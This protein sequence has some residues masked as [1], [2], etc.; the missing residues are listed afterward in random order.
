MTSFVTAAASPMRILYVSSVFISFL[1]SGS[2]VGFQRFLVTP[3]SVEVMEGADVFLRCIVENQQGKAQWTKDGFALG[4]ERQVPGYP[5][6]SYSG[7]PALGQHHLVISGIT[8]TEDGEYQCQVGPTQT[9]PPIW[10]AANVTVLVAPR[11]VEFSGWRDGSV[12]EVV[13]G[14]SITLECLVKDARPAPTVWWYRDGLQ[15]DQ[16]LVEER[17]EASSLVRRWSVRSRIALTASPEDDGKLFTCEAD[18]PALRG[19]S[20]PLLA[21]ITLSVLHQPG[22]PTISGYKTGEVLVAGERRTLVCRVSGG[23]P[24][25]WVTWHRQGLLLD[26]TT[27]SD[28]AGV[29]NTHQLTATA[30]DDGAIYECR[31]NSDLLQ[32]PMVANV[33]LT[34]YYV[35]SFV[36][37]IGP[38]QVE[39]GAS[40]SLTC[41]TSK[42]NPP[43]SIIWRVQGETVTGEPETMVRVSTGGWVTTSQL[44]HH[45]V[46]S[47]KVT[48]VVVECRAL[49][50][51][52][53]QIVSKTR[54]VAI[55]KPA[56]PPRFEGDLERNFLAGTT[57]DLVCSSIGGHPPPTIRIY[58]EEEE[59][60]TE[61][62]R[63][64]NVTRGRGSVGLTP[65]DNGA[66]VTCEV[67]NAGS[68]SAP[69]TVY[70]RLVVR[71]A[72][73]EV[74]GSVTPTTVEEGA[75]VRLS[76]E[77]SSSLPPSNITWRSE[78]VTLDGATITNTQGAFGGTSTRSEVQV[79]TTAGDNGRKFVC[80]ASNGLGPPVHTT[81]TTHVLHPPVWLSRPPPE[82]DVYEGADLIVSASAAANPGPLRYWWRRGEE[83]LM[84]TGQEL[85]LGRISR[86]N[87]GHYSVSAYS[88]RG[89]V[90]A[91]FYLNVQYGPEKVES[92]D[93]VS[94]EENG[95]VS[96]QCSA[97]G[98]PVPHLTWTR[99]P[100]NTHNSSGAPLASGVGVARLVMES[101]RRADTG[102]YLCHARN[103]VGS[104]P[105]TRTYVVVAQKV[106]AAA[107]VQGL[108]GSWAAVGGIGR[109]VC[110]VRAAPPP[111]FV[112]SSQ[113]GLILLNSDKYTIHEPQLVDGLVLWSSVLEVK[114][115]NTQ[116][117]TL[118]RCHAH[119]AHGSDSVVVALNPPSRPHPPVNF[120]INK[121]VGGE[122]WV[123]WAPNLEGGAPSGYTLR[124]R[125]AGSSVYQYVEVSGGGTTTARVTGLA[126]ATEYTAAIQA[127]NDHG[128]SHFV[129]LSFFTLLGKTDG[130]TSLQGLAGATSKLP[131]G[132]LAAKPAEGADNLSD[133]DRDEDG[134][135]RVPRLI[136]LIMT[137][138]GAALLALNISIIACFVRRRAMNRHPSGASSSKTASLGTFGVTPASTPGV[139]PSEVFLSLNTMSSNDPSLSPSEYQNG[140]RPHH[141]GDEAVQRPVEADSPS[142]NRTA[143]PAEAEASHFD[144]DLVNFPTE[145]D[146]CSL[147][148]SV[149]D[150]VPPDGPRRR[151][152][153]SDTY[154]ADDQFSLCSDRSTNS[155]HVY[156]QGF[157]RPLSSLGG[158]QQPQQATPQLIQD[159]LHALPRHS[160]QQHLLRLAQA[161]QLFLHT[162]QQHLHNLQISQYHN[163]AQPRH[164]SPRETRQ[165]KPQSSEEQKYSPQRTQHQNNKPL[166][167]HNQQGTQNSQ[168]PEE[169]QHPRSQH[170]LPAS[171]ERELQLT[172]HLQQPRRRSLQNPTHMRSQSCHIKQ[173]T[174]PN[175]QPQQ[176]HPGEQSPKQRSSP[177]SQTRSQQHLKQTRSHQTHTRKPQPHTQSPL[178]Q[179]PRSHSSKEQ[180]PQ[181][182]LQQANFQKLPSEALT[183]PPAYSN[184]NP[185]DL[186]SFK[187]DNYHV[188][189]RQ[190]LSKGGGPA[191]YST[192]GT[193]RRR[194]TPTHF[195]TLQRPRSSRTQTKQ[196]TNS[197]SH[198]P[199]EP[200]PPDTFQMTPFR[201]EIEETFCPSSGVPSQQEN[202]GSSGYSSSP[203]H[204]TGPSA[205]EPDQRATI[206]QN[207]KDTVEAN[208]PMDN[209]R[210]F[211]DITSTN[212]SKG[213][214][215]AS[216]I[217]ASLEHEADT[218]DTSRK[219][220][221]HNN[222]APQNDR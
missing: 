130:P 170:Q 74:S 9:N 4:F 122:V 36:S 19:G 195:A 71:F 165:H 120:T 84:G 213:H 39:E 215:A 145:P 184:L 214:I 191:G 46:R 99:E 189:Y 85:Q 161:Q 136:L 47:R 187:P 210:V 121:M 69:L 59:V 92:S 168:S 112:W 15:L 53:E 86:H 219:P 10:A 173:Q 25:P 95:R 163:N 82:V 186:F 111:T 80:E 62:T 6:Y 156:S 133:E 131:T 134:G 162:P 127:T 167:Q 5:R 153:S 87:T 42:S 140:E 51:A 93:R 35:P 175:A 166:Q 129:S 188:D 68:T 13:A 146:V 157:L 150:N 17:V 148:S 138:T 98:N 48:E 38:T 200:C 91:S 174:D 105:P 177:E 159:T 180:S 7:D 197:K 201:F 12:V 135:S 142:S 52:I 107:D 202:S 29:I 75:I 61:V 216:R 44:T 79:R 192:L 55:T 64:L 76:C 132:T 2:A 151:R 141:A 178:Q 54:I 104:A 24:R 185:I 181:T 1:R 66:R 183:E 45:K 110:H 78:D 196:N 207:Q 83:T 81:L 97:S 101:A 115:I 77:S 56:G 124:Y 8:I 3:E 209:P 204:D 43:V 118:Y 109:L 28:A 126:P 33:S 70:A 58:K 169:H 50:P 128:R 20:D 217:Q 11:S 171:H 193:R 205:Q 116:D 160:Q 88:Q 211:E 137:L 220:R 49:N 139:H 67:A 72:P 206:P 34:V 60:P 73:W 102:V 23:N 65:A 31:V 147:G 164:H 203:P 154:P 194:Q 218:Q 123:S 172:S 199:D 63:E 144:H 182:L 94:V 117:Y 16:G 18:H 113:S 26:D 143:S 100:S 149:Y 37:L 190:S 119:N 21:S 41:E 22:P 198:V 106:T 114:N 103:V 27:T 125:P 57:L 222:T 30:A 89:A 40:I 14:S 208:S 90:N 212:A 176:L 152:T 221:E 32:E 158:V 179:T 96:I 108:R 155:H